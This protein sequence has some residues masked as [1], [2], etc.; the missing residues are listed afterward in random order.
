MPYRVGGDPQRALLELSKGLKQAGRGELRKQFHKQLRESAKPLLPAVRASARDRFPS[1]GG[2]NRHMARGSRYRTVVYTG[3]ATGTVSIRANRTDPR[4]D[5]EGRIVHPIPR[6]GS[7]RVQS[8][9]VR[10]R[11]VTTKM[12]GGE[13]QRDERGR[14]RVAVQIFPRAV[15]YFRQPIEAGAPAI[16]DDIVRTLKEWSRRKFEG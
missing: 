9:N 7:H 12:E 13:W 5:S 15:G 2:L 16:R 10:T 1:R 11:K 3:G 8:T 6:A 14:R 4:T